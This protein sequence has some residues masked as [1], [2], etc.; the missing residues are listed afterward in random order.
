MSM[1]DKDISF[2]LDIFKEI[3]R[4]NE[5]YKKLPDGSY[6]CPKCGSVIQQTTAYVS[7]WIKGFSGGF[8]E[9]ERYP[10]P[11]CPKCEG[12]PK[13]VRGARY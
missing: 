10:F 4:R 3:E 13:I 7:V 1:K 5:S 9:V 11:Y 8:G 6:K 12:E 2:G